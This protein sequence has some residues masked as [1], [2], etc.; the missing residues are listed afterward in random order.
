[1]DNNWRADIRTWAQILSVTS[2]KGGRDDIVAIAQTLGA[3]PPKNWREAW[4]FIQTHPDGGWRDSIMELSRSLVTI[5]PKDWREALR[6]IR[7]YQEGNPP[8]ARAL[9]D[10]NLFRLFDS[11]GNALFVMR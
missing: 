9:F 8:V 7:M 4:R 6:F 1:M 11:N 3:T 5:P 10:V 2:D